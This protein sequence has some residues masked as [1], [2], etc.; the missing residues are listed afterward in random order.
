MAQSIIQKVEANKLWSCGEAEKSEKFKIQW[1][2]N[3]GTNFLDARASA[4]AITGYL[5]NVRG[6]IRNKRRLHYNEK[7]KKLQY[8]IQTKHI[9][10][11]NLQRTLH[12]WLT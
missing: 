11:Q 7:T 12:I 6:F 9:K 4:S 1:K 2:K 5:R 8:R 10:V 3:C